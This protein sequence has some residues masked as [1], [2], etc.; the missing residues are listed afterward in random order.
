MQVPNI[1]SKNWL[2]NQIELDIEQTQISA[3]LVDLPSKIVENKRCLFEMKDLSQDQEPIVRIILSKVK[4]WV[5]L[6]RNNDTK[7][8]EKFKPL[9]L[10]IRG[11]AGTGKSFIT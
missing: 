1:D 2:L 7:E 4:E 8:L 11:K 9:R 3:C 10:T 6:N 5:E